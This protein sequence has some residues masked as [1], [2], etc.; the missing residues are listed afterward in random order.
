MSRLL[1]MLLAL[2]SDLERRWPGKAESIVSA[3]QDFDLG[4]LLKAMLNPTQQHVAAE[5]H[6]R[7]T[8]IVVCGPMAMTDEVRCAVAGL[9]RNGALVRMIVEDFSW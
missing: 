1:D 3:R 9:V 7:D 4:V 8:T 5:K 2:A 6:Q